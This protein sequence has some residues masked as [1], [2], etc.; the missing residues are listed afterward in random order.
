[1]NGRGTTDHASLV[2]SLFTAVASRLAITR[3]SSATASAISTATDAASVLETLALARKPLAFTVAG[4]LLAY[5]T[6]G[7]DIDA[8]RLRNADANL[9]AMQRQTAPMSGMTGLG[10]GGYRADHEQ[11]MYNPAGRFPSNV[12]LSHGPQC[13]PVGRN[14]VP[15]GTAHRTNG[16]GKTFGGD[17]SKPPL[18]D[19]G[20]AGEDGR[21]EVVQWNCEASCP[22]QALDAQAGERPGMSG[23]GKHRED[24]AGGMFGGIDSTDTARGDSGGASRFFKTVALTEEDFRYVPKASRFERELGCEHLP[25]RAGFEAVHR[26]EG[27]AGLNP[28]AGAGRTADKVHNWGPCIKPVALTRW[29]AAMLLPRPHADGSQ[30]RLLIPFCGTGSEILG[31]LRAGF[32]EVV[33]IQRAADDDERGFIAIARARLA[34]WAEVPVDVDPTEA[35]E[36]VKAEKQA[37]EAGQLS[38]LGG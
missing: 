2:E 12:V 1:M 9:S 21:E 31:G 5:E 17:A 3:T 18:E 24:Y 36:G 23:G 16:G 8:G 32:D 38:L 19:L 37:R 28:R 10:K 34:R 14:R 30:R 20:Y 27:S 22:V 29:L 6:G 13:R 26:E 4:N 33:G 25:A 11:P 7:L 35:T 15:S